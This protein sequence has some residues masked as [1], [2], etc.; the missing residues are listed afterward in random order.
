M[1]TKKQIIEKAVASDSFFGFDRQVY[2]TYLTFDQAKPLLKP[3]VKKED[4]GRARSLS[5]VEADM[6]SYMIFAIGKACDHRGISANRSVEKMQAYTAILELENQIDWERY[7]NYGAPILK[8]ICD[9]M[10][11]QEL[12]TTQLVEWDREPFARMAEGKK[13]RDDCEEGC[14]W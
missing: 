3:D 7:R 14:G 13:C 12:Y 11:W 8:Q 4:W 6:K 9:L 2:A 1:L 5:K 10:G